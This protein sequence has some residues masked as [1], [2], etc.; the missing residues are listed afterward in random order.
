[1]KI[2]DLKEFNFYV[3]NTTDPYEDI[4]ATND[5]IEGDCGVIAWY[6]EDAEINDEDDLME[7][8]EDAIRSCKFF[9][10]EDREGLLDV[11]AS[12]CADSVT[13]WWNKNH[14]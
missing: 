7:V 6:D 11:F 12:E 3:G 5:G 14:K 10:E 8:I 2:T 13:E 4:A 9:T 1:M